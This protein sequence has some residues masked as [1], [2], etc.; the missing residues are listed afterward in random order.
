MTVEILTKLNPG[1]INLEG[2]RGG[3]P[4]ITFEDVC[5]ALAPASQGAWLTLMVI[6]GQSELRNKLKNH[7]YVAAAG[8]CGN[9][10]K[11]EQEKKYNIIERLTLLAIEE[12]IDDK[13]CPACKGVKYLASK[14]C[15]V[16]NGKGH[17]FKVKHKVYE[18]LAP[19]YDAVPKSRVKYWENYYNRIVNRLRGWEG[20]GYAEIYKYMQEDNFL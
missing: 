3:V 11:T 6:H 8:I 16:C 14:K 15:H 20:E 18:Q 9:I 4:D 12:V 19:V 7:L 17:V 13:K 10:K 2:V 1:S 5:M